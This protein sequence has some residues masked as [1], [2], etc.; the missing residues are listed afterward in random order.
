MLLK[1]LYCRVTMEK[2]SLATTG[3]REYE[4]PGSKAA[5]EVPVV[6]VAAVG[7]G[8]LAGHLRGQGEGGGAGCFY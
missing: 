7:P 4:I 2:Q 8:R 1:S 6:T 3:L 5:A